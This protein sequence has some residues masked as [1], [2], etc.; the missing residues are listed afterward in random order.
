MKT[1][2][3]ITFVTQHHMAT[4]ER[5]PP[6]EDALGDAAEGHDLLHDAAIVS[7]GEDDV[8]EGVDSVLP[9][10]SDD[11]ENDNIYS[12]DDEDDGKQ[13]VL[14]AQE[15]EAD[16]LLYD[17]NMDDE[18]QAYVYQYLRGG[19]TTSVDPT[20][21]SSNSSDTTAV[22][23]ASSTNNRSPRQKQEK[24]SRHS[25]AV[26]SCP[27]CF[28]IV[29]MDCQRHEKYA[30][31]FRAMFVMG[32]VVHWQSLLMYDEP[33]QQLVPVTPP[34]LVP[35]AVAAAEEGQQQQAD[36]VPIVDDDGHPNYNIFQ[37]GGDEEIYY[38]VHCDNCGTQVAALDMKDEVYHFFGCLASG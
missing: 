22:A 4:M 31:Q 14:T 34:V 33:S 15:H 24:H 13:Q 37:H 23:A 20:T 28:N 1:Q 18:D 10:E 6:E 21:A 5:P 38:S 32:I 30:D 3:N 29:C 7:A 9:Y 25:D 8:E 12:D 27:A 16:A 19:G 26:L 35:A 11:E 36:Q 17:A 2:R